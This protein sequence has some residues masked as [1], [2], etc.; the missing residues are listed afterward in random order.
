MQTWRDIRGRLPVVDGSVVTPSG[1]DERHAGLIPTSLV[2]GRAPTDIS[3]DL[4]DCP[5]VLGA[6]VKVGR[7]SL[8][9]LE[10]SNSWGTLDNEPTEAARRHRGVGA[11][12]IASHAQTIE[13]ALTAQDLLRRDDTEAI[14]R[15]VDGLAQRSVVHGGRSSVPF[16]G[17]ATP[18]A[19]QMYVS[20][21]G[22]A[23][24]REV[25]E[26]VI[27]TTFDA[28]LAGAQISS[29]F[30]SGE[31]KQVLVFSRPVVAVYWMAAA[32]LSNG[33]VRHCE[34]CGAPFVVEEPRQR[35][36][37]PIAPWRAAS[38]CSAN[39]R[40]R[41]QRATPARPK[42]G[43]KALKKAAHADKRKRTT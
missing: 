37:P 38:A 39:M 22:D 18:E 10:F 43:S 20:P 6:L 2:V 7:G 9:V 16:F 34:Y 21:S 24:D 12:W 30:D 29:R 23:S 8:D 5:G 14:R 35:Y 27:S 40:K 15:M 26:H 19:F 28:N 31:F 42:R 32:A 33:L 36:C 4:L 17:F 25:I 1:Y 3:Y 11:D 13:R 41:R